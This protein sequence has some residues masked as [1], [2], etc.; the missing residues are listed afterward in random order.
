MQESNYIVKKDLPATLVN[1]AIKK[2][3]LVYIDSSIYGPVVQIMDKWSS[4]RY[5]LSET[6]LKEHFLPISSKNAHLFFS[7]TLT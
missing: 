5:F 3:Q 6:E 1:C 4:T 2:G 7:K